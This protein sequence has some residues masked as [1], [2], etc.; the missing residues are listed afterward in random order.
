MS[1]LNFKII[2]WIFFCFF[3]SNESITQN[4]PIEYI[5]SKKDSTKLKAYI[6]YP[7][8]INKLNPAIIIFHGGGW[9]S[10]EP[11]W[12]FG[13]AQHFADLGLVSV[14]TQ[15]RLSNQKDITPLEAMRDACDIIIWLRNN[16][17]SLK[18]NPNK[19]AAF[20]W[21]A[22]GHLAASTAI[23]PDTL[24]NINSI[25]NALV[26]I[27]PAV[28]ISKDTWVK[29]IL[30]GKTDIKSISPAEHIRKGLPP[31]IILQG[32]DDTVTPLEG[33]KNFTK[34]MLSAKNKC[35][36]IVYKKVGHLFTPSHLPDYNQPMPDKKIQADAYKKIKLFLKR[37]GY[38][39]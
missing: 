2:G 7:I 39:E 19:V 38:I 36:L 11:S 17:D 1:G 25:P 27:S 10:G 34:Q 21:S 9:Y 32:Y 4:N 16:A 3:V 5:Y 23:F 37:H 29:K 31:T 18:I 28:S 13:R 33:A 6:F 15:Y 35:E 26:L 30:L 12:A 14:V 20:G 22:G 24:L 8:K